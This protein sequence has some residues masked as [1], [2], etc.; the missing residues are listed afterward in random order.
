MVKQLMNRRGGIWTRIC[1][2][3]KFRFILPY[4]LLSW[5][6]GNDGDDDKNDYKD[7]NTHNNNS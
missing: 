7:V 6:S 2:I 5:K 1:S 3:P 4:M